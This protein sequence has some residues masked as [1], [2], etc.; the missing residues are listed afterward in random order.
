MKRFFSPAV[1]VFVTLFCI[2][3]IKLLLASFIP[4]TADEAYYAIWGAYLSGGG[5]DHP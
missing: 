2:T 5:Y 1:C 4:I 3:V